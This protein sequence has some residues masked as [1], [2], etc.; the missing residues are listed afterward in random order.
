[1]HSRAAEYRI[2]P[3]KLE[4]F[5]R[6]IHSLLPMLRQQAGFRAL[7]ILRTS[8]GD[9][10]EAM[11]ISVWDSLSDLKASE[12]NMFLYQAISRLLEFCEGFPPIREY[13]VL[14]SEFAAD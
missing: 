10:P 14:I 13:E 11:S 5:L 3:G 6:A 4:D 1:M 8:A 7:V 12:E 2:L 9:P